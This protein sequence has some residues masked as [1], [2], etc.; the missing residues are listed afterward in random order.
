[1]AHLGEA[2]GVINLFD[3][4][5]VTPNLFEN[6]S[7][8]CLIT[9]EGPFEAAT[10]VASQLSKKSYVRV[11]N[12]GIAGALDKSLKLGEI[13]PVR[14]VYLVVSA[15]PQF[16]SFQ[17]YNQGLDCIT[18]FERILSSEKTLPLSGLGALVDR[19]AWGVAMATKSHGVSFES[20]KLVSDFAGTLGACELIKGA[21]EDF[22]QK[23]AQFLATKIQLSKKPEH[24]LTLEGFHFTFSTR[25]RFQQY[26]KK[27]SLREEVKEE[28]VLKEI[29]LKCIRDQKILPKERTCLLLEAMEYRLDPLKKKLEEGLKSWKAP[30]TAHSIDLITDP[31]WEV[32]EV[33]ISFQVRSQ[34]ELKEKLEALSGLNLGPFQRLRNGEFHVE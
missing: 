26:L 32:P 4:K 18:S 33:K 7:L 2:Q 15:S 13:Y 9:G 1:M 19:E 23:L 27:I 14:S 8:S 31:T 24:E 5:R 11:L 21:A 29:D 6:D 22:S 10:A 34:E 17:S 30:F 25:I 28:E 16:K 20:Y 12:L 3:L